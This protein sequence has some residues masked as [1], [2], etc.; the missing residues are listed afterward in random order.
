M[1]DIKEKI[2]EIINPIMGAWGCGLTL[3]K[4]GEEFR[5]GYFGF[6]HKLHEGTE[7][8]TFSFGKV[9]FET[10]KTAVNAVIENTEFRVFEGGEPAIKIYLG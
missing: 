1:T 10:L 7:T 3:Y 2:E 6:G 4:K 9:D 8:R 5:W